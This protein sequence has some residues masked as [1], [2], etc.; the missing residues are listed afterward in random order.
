[1][2][3]AVGDRFQ[4]ASALNAAGWFHARLGDHQQALGR[5]EQALDLPQGLGSLRAAAGTWDSLGCI[6]HHL[7]DDAGQVR[8]ELAGLGADPGA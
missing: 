2:F 6:R 4:Q 7:G 8:A 3:M 5:C 1:M